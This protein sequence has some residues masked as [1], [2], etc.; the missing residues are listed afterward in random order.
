M[1]AI[2]I[3][4]FGAPDVMA[5]EDLDDPVP[6]NGEVLIRHTYVGVNFAD[7]STRKGVYSALPE[8]P[9]IIGL[10]GAGVIEELGAGVADF[11]VGQRV[12]YVGAIGSYAEHPT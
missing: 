1:K 6:G 5:I 12:T 2:V 11:K 4:E 10:E 8:L 7:L 9:A 3:H